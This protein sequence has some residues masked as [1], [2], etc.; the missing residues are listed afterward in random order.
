MRLEE[1]NLMLPVNAW[2][3]RAGVH[4]RKVIEDFPG[5]DGCGGLSGELAL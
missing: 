4:D 5:I 2:R 3:V 1:A